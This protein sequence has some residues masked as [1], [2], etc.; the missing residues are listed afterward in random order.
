MRSIKGRVA[1]VTGASSGI[2]LATARALAD[3]GAKVHAVARRR[4]EGLFES[5]CVDVTNANAVDHLMREIGEREG[6]DILVLAAG[7]NI[8]NRK[9]EQLTSASWDELVAV[10]LNSA[11]YCVHSAYAYLRSSRGTVVLIGSVSGYWPDLAAGSAYQAA[12]S[13]LLAFCRGANLEEHE[14]G[15]RFS[16]ILPGMTDTPMLN[17]RPTSVGERTRAHC[18]QPED[19]ADLCL[20]LVSM[21]PEA[22]IPE[23]TIL[24]TALQA[25]GKPAI[26]MR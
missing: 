24:P 13:G 14:R 2:G 4:A 17:Q 23:V 12:K 18:L 9:L 11:F 20:Y 22:Y 16:T 5:H 25:V 1:V 26:Q 10:N 19:I 6:I 21:R 8:P 7:L 3:A 15:V